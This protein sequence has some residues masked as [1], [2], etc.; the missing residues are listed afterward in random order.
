[1]ARK[2]DDEKDDELLDEEESSEREDASDGEAEESDEAE[3]SED[4][5]ESQDDADEPSNDAE[6][7]DDE[8]EAAPASK[9]EAELAAEARA[10]ANA[11]LA[12]ETR[13]VESLGATRYVHAAFFGAGILV[14]YLSSKL[15]TALWN[16]LA[17]WPAATRAVPFLLRY[18][19]EERGTYMQ[20]VGAVLGIALVVQTYR[21]ENVR[22]WANEVA[23]EMSKVTWPSKETVQNGTVVVIVC[24]LI[25]TVYVAILDRIWGFLS[26]LVYG[27]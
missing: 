11:D 23:L 20:L 24:S 9:E 27:A 15:L 14:A 22:R 18:A 2:D 13:I 25:A 10:L 7:S 17:D 26:H 4:S 16:S 8:E 6:G 12:A 1:M 21:K 5:E 19:E 3:A